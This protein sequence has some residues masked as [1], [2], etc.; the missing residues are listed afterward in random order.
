[1]ARLP[2]MRTPPASSPPSL[3]CACILHTHGCPDQATAEDMLCDECRALWRQAHQHA[4]ASTYW[5][6]GKAA[7][8]HRHTRSSRP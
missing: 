1:M 6:V 3:R 4:Q 8:Q 5:Q 7:A 2:S